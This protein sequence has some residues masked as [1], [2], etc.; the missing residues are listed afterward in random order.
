[1]SLATHHDNFDCWNSKHQPWNCV[2]IGPKRDIVGTRDVSRLQ[3]GLFFNEPA[4]VVRG[5]SMR[6]ANDRYG[7]SAPG[8]TILGQA[9]PCLVPMKPGDGAATAL[10]RICSSVI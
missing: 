7:S 3:L 8:R 2:N 4:T 10:I 6:D 1:M 9:M 5:S